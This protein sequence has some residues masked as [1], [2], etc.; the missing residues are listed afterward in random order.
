VRRIARVVDVSF[1]GPE[2]LVRAAIA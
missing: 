2:L 1:D